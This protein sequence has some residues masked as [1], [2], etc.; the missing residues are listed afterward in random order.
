MKASEK[1][2]N[3]Y[4]V[5]M[6]QLAFIVNVPNQTVVTALDQEE[7]NGNVLTNIDGAVIAQLDLMEAMAADRLMRRL[8]PSNQEEVI[9]YDEITLFWCI[10]S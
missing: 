7:S 6:D 4:I 10:R 2:I 9:Y 5:I 1:G 8:Q 3:E